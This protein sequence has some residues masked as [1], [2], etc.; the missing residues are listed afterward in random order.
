M[1]LL[2]VVWIRQRIN[3][4]VNTTGSTKIKR[5]M[6]SVRQDD[7]KGDTIPGVDKKLGSEECS[8]LP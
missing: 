3:H 6:L 2:L 1:E 4:E 8:A 5:Q 7:G